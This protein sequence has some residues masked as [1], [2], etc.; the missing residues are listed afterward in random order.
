[1]YG[2][3]MSVEISAALTTKLKKQGKLHAVRRISTVGLVSYDILGFEG[4]G[5]V[6]KEIINRYLNEEA[7]AQQQPS[8]SLDITP[9]NY[10]FSY[11]NLV[12]LDGRNTYLFDITPLHKRKGLFKGQIWIDVSSSLRVQESGRLVKLPWT[13][14]KITFVRKYQIQDGISLPRQQQSKVDVRG[15]PHAE[16]TIDFSN[17]AI[18]R[19]VGVAAGIE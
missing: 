1:M 8:H 3:T 19:A 15:G 16:I 10:K 6:K 4:D 7:E 2:S 5:T 14:K 11:K 18:D 13:V 9:E 12:E 17:F